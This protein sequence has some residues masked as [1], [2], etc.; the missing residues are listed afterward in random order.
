MCTLTRN[1]EKANAEHVV[2]EVFPRLVTEGSAKHTESAGIQGHDDKE[3]VKPS[4]CRWNE[5]PRH[6]HCEVS[7]D[8]STGSGHG[9]GNIWPEAVFSSWC[10]VCL[11]K[12]VT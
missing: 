2:G 12:V 8:N 5:S 6:S 10:L 4:P 3:A 7:A 9:R 11:G 1:S